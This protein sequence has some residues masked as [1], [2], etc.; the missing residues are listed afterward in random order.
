M[1]EIDIFFSYACRDT[2]KVFKW[3]HHL[4]N[5]GEKLNLV[6][7]PYGVE[8]ESEHQWQQNWE[9]ARSELRGFIAAE[10]AREQGNDAFRRFHRFLEEAVH[11]QYFELGDEAVLIRVADRAQLDLAQF[12]ADIQSPSLAKAAYLSHQRGVTEF[13]I[14]GTPML[15]L[16]GHA[17]LYLEFMDVPQQSRARGLFQSIRALA[18]EQLDVIQLKRII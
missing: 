5:L 15:I 11:E 16:D 13:K 12:R 4:E 7:H 3:L 9:T 6:W 14:F 10:A 17:P 1:M 2:Y 18:V 8:I